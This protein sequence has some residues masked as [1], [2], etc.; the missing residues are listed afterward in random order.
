MS[1]VRFSQED[2]VNDTARITTSTWT[3]NTNSLTAVHTSS[4]QAAFGSPTSL[5]AH[6]I[7]VFDKATSY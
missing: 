4:T 1:F 7:E 2:I 5:G 6:F 3:G